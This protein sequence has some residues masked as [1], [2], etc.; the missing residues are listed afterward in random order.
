MNIKFFTTTFLSLLLFIST[1]FAQPKYIFYLIGDGMGLN[2]VNLAEIYS[3]EL[4]GRIGYQPLAFSQFP[5]VGFASTNSASS[6]ITDSGAGG[7]ALAVGK[8]THNGVIGMDS[9]ATVPQRSIAYAAKEAGLK[10][11]IT[12]SV[13]IDHATPAAFYAHQ[14]KRSYAYEIASEIPTSGF[15]FFAGSGFVSPITTFDKKSVEDIH[16]LLA[17]KGYTIVRGKHALRNDN[18]AGKK[19]VWLNNESQDKDAL[20]YAIDQTAEDMS[21]EDITKDAIKALSHNNT[22]GFFL[23][24]EGGKIDWASHANDGATTV[25]EVLDFNKTVQAAF[26]FYKKH[27]NETLIVV[28]ADHETGGL[29]LGNGPSSLN[30]KALAHQKVSQGALSTLIGNLRKSQ[31]NATWDEVKNLIAENTG[32][33]TNLKVS[34]ADEKEIKAAYEKSFVNHQ[35]ETSKSLYANDDKIASLSVR[36]LNKIANVGW[37]STNHTAAYVPVYAIGVGAEVFNQKMDNTDIPKKIAEATK[38]NFNE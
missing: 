11:G 9:A 23:M 33:W 29:S 10:V 5:Y 30:L 36:I 12:T 26:D 35:N 4:Q 2:H 34:E 25:K 28:T 1:S 8:K 21:L 20:K 18:H 22:K 24:V 14:P 27:P 17:T 19:I 32:L 13:S 16:T 31:P 7:T 37:S 15:D 3:A 6:S 38:F